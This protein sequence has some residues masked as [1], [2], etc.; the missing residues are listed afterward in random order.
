MGDTDWRGIGRDADRNGVRHAQP[1][2]ADGVS[3]PTSG[4]G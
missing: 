3:F 1:P 2:S 4:T